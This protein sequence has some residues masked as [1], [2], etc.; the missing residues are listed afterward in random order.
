MR[1]LD[2]TLNV[3]SQFLLTS[4]HVNVFDNG[5]RVQPQIP[6]GGFVTFIIYSLLVFRKSKIILSFEILLRNGP[7]EVRANTLILEKDTFFMSS[8]EGRDS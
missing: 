7:L 6:K 1:S 5:K 3:N 8:P 2:T 4:K